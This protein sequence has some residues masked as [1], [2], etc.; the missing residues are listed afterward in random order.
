MIPIRKEGKPKNKAESYRPISLTSC[1]GKLMERI[2]N[3]RLQW[4]LEQNDMISNEQAG[5]RQFRCTED[6]VTYISQLI[7]DGYQE[8]KHT[9]TIWVDMEKAFDKVWT[10]GLLLK[11][12]RARISHNMLSWI[13]DYLT[14]RKARVQSQNSKSRLTS[15]INGVPQGGVLSPTLFLLFINDICKIKCNRVKGAMYADDLALICTEESIGTAKARLQMT[16]DDLSKWTKDWGMK[17]NAAKT[18]YTTF[19]LST[20]KQSIKLT[21]DGQN[22]KEDQSPKYLG[23]RFDPRLTW[24]HQIEENQQKGLKRMQLLR[25]L[26]GTTWGANTNVLKK[27]Y[28]GYVRPALDYGITAW[29]TCS[30]AQ[31]Q[32]VEKVQNQCLRVITGA[33]KTTP[34]HR[35][36]SHTGIKAMSD[37]RDSKILTQY[38]K[39]KFMDSQPLHQKAK[40]KK[41]NRLKRSNFISMGQKLESVHQVTPRQ[42]IKKIKIPNDKPPPWK[43]NGKPITVNKENIDKRK[44]AKE[45]RDDATKLIDTS[46]PHH[47]W[48]RI[49]TDGS[50]AGPHR[51]GGAGV[52]IQWTDRTETKLSTP[53]GLLSTSCKAEEKAILTAIEEL[54]RDQRLNNKN[55]VFLTDSDD[56]LQA[57]DNHKTA[58]A[59]NTVHAL[60]S[61]SNKTNQIILQWIPGHVGIKG[62]EIADQLAKEGTLLEQPETEI[63]FPQQ[64][65]I[66]KETLA[67]VWDHSHDHMK[68]DP[69]NTLQ[70]SDQV[71]IFRLR[72]GHNRLKQHMYTKLGIGTTPYCTCGT[73]FENT[74]HILMHCPLYNVQRMTHWTTPTSLNTKLFG[75]AEDLKRTTDFIA[76][77]ELQP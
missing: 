35:M 28:L 67:Q 17:V 5:F 42:E 29:G 58:V 32:K 63:T 55:V 64:K 43:R 74:Q 2:V 46:F 61:L 41:T 20:K 4:Y 1:L 70:R 33:M 50:V 36:E 49:Y 47:N 30:N 38:T 18:T 53:V 39:V 51:N 59:S 16:L 23:V 21:L 19:S 24:K 9:V 44:R 11:L 25:K 12:K 26:A 3:R 45:L 62:N 73:D 52:L 15:M 66:I 22:L 69:I 27:T 48:I 14:N 31:F 65:V 7:E 54:T 68:N 71:T 57:I 75:E 72:T 13:K 77:I 6:Q 76:D 8:K 34:I 56:I 40:G 60:E 37:Q 10:K